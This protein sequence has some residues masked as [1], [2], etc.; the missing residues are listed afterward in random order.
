MGVGVPLLIALL[1]TW[2]L[3]IK[4]VPDPIVVDNLELFATFFSTI[5]PFELLMII[6]LEE[7]DDRLELDLE[8]LLVVV[9]VVMVIFGG[10]PSTDAGEAGVLDIIW[11]ELDGRDGG[12]DGG[13]DPPAEEEAEVM[14]PPTCAPKTSLA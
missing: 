9:V 10:N 13:L 5:S 6:V 12:R 8:L 4:V 2:T 14:V 3:L 11:T 1:L 7:D